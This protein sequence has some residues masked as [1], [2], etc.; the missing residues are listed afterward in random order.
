MVRHSGMSLHELK[1]AGC[2]SVKDISRSY[3]TWIGPS[4]PVCRGTTMHR[5]GP[6]SKAARSAVALLVAS[7]LTATTAAQPVD[8][9]DGAG[10]GDDAAWRQRMEARMQQLERENAELR[11]RVNATRAAREAV[12]K[13]AQSRGLLTLERR[14]E[15]TTP[16][17]FDL[18][19]Y[20]AEGDFPGSIWMPDTNV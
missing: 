4:R 14:G 15:R 2:A 9:R 5:V 16:E 12:L 7:L 18:N 1:L 3:V 20:A 10:A 13:D 17:F 8:S 6:H 19:K 11:A